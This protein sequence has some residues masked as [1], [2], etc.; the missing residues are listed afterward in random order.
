MSLSNGA[1]S[2]RTI[3]ETAQRTS[4]DSLCDLTVLAVCNDPYRLDT[5]A[6]HR[7]AK[8]FRDMVDRFLP[9][10]TVHLRG[11]HY[12]LV[13][14][15]DVKRPDNGLPY[16]NTEEAWTFLCDKAAKAGRW[17]NYVEFDRISD[18]RNAP[19][20]VHVTEP[21]VSYEGLSTGT[22]IEVPELQK[23]VFW[24]QIPEQQPYRLCFIG[25]KTSL[26]SVLEP[27]AERTQ[28]ELLLPTGEISDTLIAQLASRAVTDKRPTFVF[29]FSDFDP[30]GHHMPISL[31][32]KLQA[33]RD[34][35]Y[36]D[37]DIQVLPVA[38]KLDQVRELGLPSTP[39]K[40]TERRAD[41]WRA[42]MAHEQTEI[43]ALAALDPDALEVI[44]WDALKPFYDRNLPRRVQERQ[45]EWTLEANQL[46]RAHPAYDDICGELEDALEA[47][48]LA[49]EAFHEAQ[50]N[51]AQE[52]RGLRT[53][54]LEPPEA[55]L[56]TKTQ[57]P[58]FST[59][60]RFREATRRLIRHKGLEAFNLELRE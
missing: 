29:Y 31:A 58:L 53:P 43:D 59:S 9:E 8:W 48:K 45:Q 55:N 37:L 20:E 15:A 41:R 46:L 47:V 12:R 1:G 39:L 14:A 4:G 10:G 2:L 26:K 33:L 49:A 40:D 52:L 16:T 56:T 35:K 22:R 25:E 6:G 32:R 19:A 21:E 38:L 28:G 34:L 54:D 51:G 17:L 42:V 44:A 57:T 50:A 13:G 3:L 24:C 18:E 36:P 7:N 27:I 11:L 5:P 30:S 23:P 60:E